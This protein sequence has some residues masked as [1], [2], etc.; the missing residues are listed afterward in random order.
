MNPRKLKSTN[1]DTLSGLD[2]E[3]HTVNALVEVYGDE[4]KAA[5]RRL[6]PLREMLELARSR[7]SNLSTRRRIWIEQHG[8]KLK[9]IKQ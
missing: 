4:L 3:L 8:K 5:D 7:Q 6:E 9:R 1:G 2:S